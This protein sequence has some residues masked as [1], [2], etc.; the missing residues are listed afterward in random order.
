VGLALVARGN[1][2]IYIV[3]HDRGH[4]RV[5]L[6]NEVGDGNALAFTKSN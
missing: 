2:D 6:I 3:K 4:V 5:P 1:G